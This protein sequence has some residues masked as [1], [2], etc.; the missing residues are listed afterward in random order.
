MKAHLQADLYFC[1]VNVKSPCDGT[2]TSD[3]NRKHTET[4][5]KYPVL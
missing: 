2:D 5:K 4:V 1:T 3:M